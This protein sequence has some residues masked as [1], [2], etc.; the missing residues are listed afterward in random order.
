MARGPVPIYPDF[1]A[2]VL[3]ILEKRDGKPSTERI[4]LVLGGIVRVWLFAFKA[5]EGKEFKVTA[6]TP[7]FIDQTIGIP[8]LAQIM[9]DIGWLTVTPAGVSFPGLKEFKATQRR[10]T[11]VEKL[12]EAE[13]GELKKQRFEEFWK[14]YKPEEGSSKGVKSE[15]LLEWLKIEPMDACQ[16]DTI[17][18]GL[19]SIIRSRWSLC[20]GKTVHARRFLLRRMWEDAPAGRPIRRE[21]PGP[22]DLAP[23]GRDRDAA[24]SSEP[25]TTRTP[26]G[27]DSVQPGPTPQIRSLLGLTYAEQ[28]TVRFGTTPTTEPAG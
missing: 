13:G 17:M 21:V 27:S 9:I 15:A 25:P 23:P 14:A 12:A 16:F 1:T 28:P 3:K 2:K 8:G 26:Q 10:K 11:D 7:Q 5:G 24:D 19:R 4:S 20:N 22:Q 6:V 18:Q